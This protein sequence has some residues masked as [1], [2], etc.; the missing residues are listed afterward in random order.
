M[1]ALALFNSLEAIFWMN[2]GG[3]VFWKSRGN[4]RHGTLGLIAAG[5]F[6]LFGASDVW[7]V[8]TGARWRPWP[9]LLLKATC[10]ISLI[11]C[12]VIYRNTLREDSMRLDLRQDVSSRCRSLPLSAVD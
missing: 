11:L 12:A 5:W 2:L 3:L 8:F 7:E 6:V 4:P 1:D 9:L 10:V